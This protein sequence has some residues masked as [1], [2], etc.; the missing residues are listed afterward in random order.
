MRSS[1][2][3]DVYAVR[4]KEKSGG[5]DHEREVLLATESLRFRVSTGVARSARQTP[6]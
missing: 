5:L 4:F 6:N 1:E 3:A 2:T